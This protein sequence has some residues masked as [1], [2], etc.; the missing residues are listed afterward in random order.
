HQRT[1]MSWLLRLFTR[2]Y[3][4]SSS[5]VGWLA[6]MYIWVESPEMTSTPPEIGTGLVPPGSPGGQGSETG[7]WAP[8]GIQPASARQTRPSMRAPGG[9]GGRELPC[10]PCS[11]CCPCGPG[12]PCGPVSPLAPFSAAV[13]AGP[14]GP[15]GPVSPLGPAGPAGPALPLAPGVPAT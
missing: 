9:P 1:W 11:P 3:Q 13:P 14:A 2:V 6:V 5:R 8:A 7:Y 15:A 4:P 10:G 12:G